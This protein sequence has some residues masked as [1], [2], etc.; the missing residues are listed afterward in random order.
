MIYVTNRKAESAP[1]VTFMIDP[2]GTIHILQGT[3]TQK[4]SPLLRKA[5]PYGGS[6]A[7]DSFQ[8]VDRLI[9]IGYRVVNRYG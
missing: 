3:V 8:D 1:Q 7:P 9:S 5:W 2:D 4:D 6:I